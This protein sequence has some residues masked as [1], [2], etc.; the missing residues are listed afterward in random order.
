[1][2][3]FK[4][5]RNRE[6]VVCHRFQGTDHLFALEQIE[7]SMQGL[8]GKDIIAQRHDHE[9]FQTVLHNAE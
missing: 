5:Q 7:L 6:G 9:E 8:Q 1:M 3:I 4:K 2:V